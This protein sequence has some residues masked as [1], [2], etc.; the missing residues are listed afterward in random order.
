MKKLFIAIFAV[1]A[2][3][4]ACNFNNTT[5]EEPVVEEHQV[6]E[7]VEEVDSLA[8]VEEADTLEMVE[9]VVEEVVAE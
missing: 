5:V 1:A 6:I 8:V 4:T 7:M 9:E 3:M 2:M